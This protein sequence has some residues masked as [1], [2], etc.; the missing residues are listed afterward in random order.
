MTIEQGKITECT[1]EELMDY[2]LTRD[3]DLVISFIEFKRRFRECGCIIREVKH[4]RH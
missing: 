1:V 2:Y 3:Y 4:D